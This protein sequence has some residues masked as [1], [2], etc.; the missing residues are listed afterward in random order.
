MDPLTRDFYFDTP[1][2]ALEGI[3]VP[4]GDVW[5]RFGDAL[6]VEVKAAVD[7][8]P[9]VHRVV[10]GGAPL[11]LPMGHRIL[12]GTVHTN[13]LIASLYRRKHTLVDD[14]YPGPGGWIVQTVHN[15]GNVG[16]NAII[17][18]LS[19]PKMIGEVLNAFRFLVSSSDGAMGY[20]NRVKT[21]LEIPRLSADEQKLWK[22]KVRASFKANTG[23]DAL[24]CCI[25]SGLTYALTGYAEYLELFIF[26]IRHYHGLVRQSDGEWEF[27]HMLFPY[28]W[29]WRLAWLWDMVEESSVLSDHDRLEVITVLKGLAGY[30]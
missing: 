8:T 27:E 9:T 2:D 18:G 29:I 17:V 22:R 10:Q 16:F 13:P 21:R 11:D 20:V 26:A 6:A 14:F 12:V 15:P 1:L 24:E 7:R 5:M 19:D 30:T 4:D 28:A 25:E 23:R 3:V